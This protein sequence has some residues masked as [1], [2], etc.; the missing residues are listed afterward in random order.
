M[1]IS[2]VFRILILLSA[3]AIGQSPAPSRQNVPVAPNTPPVVGN[4]P[5][6][7]APKPTQAPPTA[8]DTKPTA[9]EDKSSAFAKP[10]A[11]AN[12]GATAYT[13][14]ATKI[15]V[16]ETILSGDKDKK[17]PQYIYAMI[18][19]SFIDNKR[20]KSG[21]IKILLHQR[22]VPNTVENFIGLVEGTKEFFDGVS[23]A[24]AKR[25][26]YNG[27]TFHRVMKNYL[28]QGG[29]PNGDGT[30]GPGFKLETE[31]NAELKQDRPGV[32]A[33]V[34][35]SQ[36][37][38]TLDA[39]PSLEG[40]HNIFGQVVEGMDVVYAIGRSEATRNEK[41][42]RKILIKEITIERVF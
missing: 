11:D 7:P 6:T 26:F 31:L 8:T 19:V 16:G 33:M 34:N 35:G 22:L 28:I 13:K 24:K 27:L 41:P 14:D 15:V 5:T 32:V 4:P 20:R 38:I 12:G 18:K 39:V 40:L 30:G 37:F 9:A 21:L 29:D 3:I 1:I 10:A 25:P 42:K 36:F 17:K 2:W 23:K